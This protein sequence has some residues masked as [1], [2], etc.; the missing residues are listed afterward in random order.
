MKHISLLFV[1]ILFLTNCKLSTPNAINKLSPTS[2]IINTYPYQTKIPSLT[3]SQHI[4]LTF[5]VSNTPTLFP[6]KTPYPIPQG[7]F[8]R[9]ELQQDMDDWVSKKII[10][11]D[12]DMLFNEETGEYVPL[13]V[14][15]KPLLGEVMFIYYN[16]GFTIIEDDQGTPYLLN[17]VGFEDRNGERFTFPFHNGK[18]LGQKPSI[19]L[20]EFD[21]KGIYQSNQ[22][23]YERLRPFVFVQKSQELIGYV[24]I[25]FSTI[26]SPGSGDES[27]VYMETSKETT[28]DLTSFFICGSCLLKDITKNL[29]KYINQIPN[30]YEPTLPYIWEYEVSY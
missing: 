24:N 4:S 29:Q 30:L 16:L 21:G 19:L 8:S 26:G 13:G 9:E 1:S 22:I 23:Y 5:S 12:K 7:V 17:I 28:N 20:K 10:L 25:G 2:P 18:L 14:Y 27:D 6:T 3:T 15:D 11:S